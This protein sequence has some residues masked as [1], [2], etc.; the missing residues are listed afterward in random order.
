MSVDSPPCEDSVILMQA[1]VDVRCLVHTACGKV[2]KEIGLDDEQVMNLIS[3]TRAE[4]YLEP[5]GSQTPRPSGVDAAAAVD[6]ESVP[7]IAHEMQ[8]AAVPAWAEK[9]SA[10]NALPT[11][12]QQTSSKG[13]LGMPCKSAPR[14]TCRWIP[15]GGL[16]GRKKNIDE[17]KGQAIPEASPMNGGS[18]LHKEP[19]IVPAVSSVGDMATER[20]S[21]HG[22]TRSLQCLM[23]DGEGGFIC[24][25][26]G[27]CLTNDNNQKHRQHLFRLQQ[28]QSYNRQH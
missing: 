14:N 25:P 28:Q 22:K 23:D 2:G 27:R 19:A 6:V 12:S 20:C 21:A 1:A 8:Q 16:G 3:Q 13:N 11:D 7:L 10:P 15:V 17:G 9:P 26:K 5:H 24:T 4:A 18:R